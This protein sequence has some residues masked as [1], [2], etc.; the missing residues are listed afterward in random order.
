ME[1][2]INSTFGELGVQ[3]SGGQKQRVGI[4]R[5]LYNDPEILIFD[6]S[7][8]SLDARTEKDFIAAITNLKKIKTIIIVSHKKSSL[9][10]CDV[11][12]ELKNKKLI[13]VG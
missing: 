13:R 5:A 6:E 4:A 2:G 10:S 12:Y 9:T 3:L 8:S 11:I 7:T 1:N